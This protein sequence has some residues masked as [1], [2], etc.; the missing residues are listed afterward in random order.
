MCVQPPYNYDCMVA[1]EY[2][3]DRWNTVGIK[4]ATITAICAYFYFFIFFI[5]GDC[6]CRTGSCRTYNILLYTRRESR[7]DQANIDL[8]F[9]L[10]VYIGT[11]L[12]LAVATCRTCRPSQFQ[13]PISRVAFRTRARVTPAPRL[14]RRGRGQMSRLSQPT[15]GLP[16]RVNKNAKPKKKILLGFTGL[17]P[18]CDLNTSCGVRVYVA[19]PD[20]AFEIEKG[21]LHS[22]GCTGNRIIH[23]Y[24]SSTFRHCSR[25]TGFW[26]EF[27]SFT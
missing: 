10:R 27:D 14:N 15:C 24:T 18:S 19:Q 3:P 13:H 16:A 2:A 25:F 12:W 4:T 6:V 9:V 26:T 1:L 21:H 22:A 8:M 11:S 5:S 17:P 20:R 23:L 7:F